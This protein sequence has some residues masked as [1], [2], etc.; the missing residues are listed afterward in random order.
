MKALLLLSSIFICIHVSCAWMTSFNTRSPLPVNR[1]IP[2]IRSS[3]FAT[4]NYPMIDFS[5]YEGLGNDFILIDNRSSSHPSLTPDQ[6]AKLCNRN[7]GIGADGVIFALSPPSPEY[8]FSMRIFNSDGSE[9]EMCG[10]GIRCLAA[11]LRDIGEDSKKTLNIHTLAGKI[12][13]VLNDDG[14]VTVDMGSPI[15]EGPRIPTTLT[16]NA[17]MNTIVDQ[18]LIC[19]QREWKVTCV[20]MGNPVRSFYH[21]I[22]YVMMITD[23]YTFKKI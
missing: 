12:V 22:D 13:P 9:P 20:S 4:T 7:F 1:F 16:P 14:T 17:D 21:I 2:L 15:L 5:K 18:T 23:C 8:D 11:F 10:N 3:L 19:N 6:S